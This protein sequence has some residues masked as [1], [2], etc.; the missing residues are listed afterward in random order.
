MRHRVKEIISGT[1]LFMVAT[2]ALG[3]SSIESANDFGLSHQE[4]IN[5]EVK[6]VPFDREEYEKIKKLMI[7]KSKGLV[8]ADMDN[9]DPDFDPERYVEKNPNEEGYWGRS[10]DADDGEFVDDW[11]RYYEG[12]YGNYER[13][14]KQDY[15][16]VQRLERE[17]RSVRERSF[18]QNQNSGS[19]LFLIIMLSI[20]L[21]VA[22]AYLF[23][24]NNKESSITKE[25]M[26]DLAPTE[27]PKSELERM[28]EAAI[29]KK[30]FRKAIRIYF[31]FIL[32]DLTQKEW[33]VWNKKKTN[34]LYLREMKGRPFYKSFRKAV[35][36]Y[37]IVW[38]GKRS[39]SEEEYHEV[40]PFFKNILTDLIAHDR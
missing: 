16:E 19:G 5:N 10:Y 37:E 25:Y 33:I 1:L 2:L 14:R 6:I 35:S 34:L 30:D 21:A 13:F 36:I 23:F 20:V 31:I 18:N 22:V 8:V 40:E 11:D 7:L 38:Y 17:Q 39:V 9:L 24:R 3:Q 28:L 4:Y 26:D 32:K 29:A 15:K 12:E 27:I